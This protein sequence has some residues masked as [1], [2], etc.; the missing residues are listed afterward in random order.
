[1]S[2]GH[3]RA[4]EAKVSLN[5]FSAAKIMLLLNERLVL[6][7]DSG[8]SE[9]PSRRAIPEPGYMRIVF[10]QKGRDLFF[11]KLLNALKMCEWKVLQCATAVFFV[12]PTL[13]FVQ[14]T[15]STNPEEAVY[16]D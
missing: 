10:H 14:A 7:A 4:A 12:S 5:M 15:P 1:M 16:N 3:I 11:D 6:S 2:L 13:T 8:P 9:P